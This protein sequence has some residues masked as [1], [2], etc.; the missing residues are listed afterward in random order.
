MV[1]PRKL[2]K[3]LKAALSSLLPN[4]SSS[5]VY[6]TQGTSFESP[7]PACFQQPACPPG[8]RSARRHRLRGKEEGPATALPPQCW[9]DGA[10][11]APTL[12]ELSMTKATIPSGRHVPG[13]PCTLGDLLVLLLCR[14]T[15]GT[16]TTTTDTTNAKGPFEM[17]LLHVTLL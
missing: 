10:A 3:F 9:S 4:N 6:K 8:L 7:S 2:K 5:W 15:G 1:S 14:A 11:E 16:D 17:C 12:P 13:Q